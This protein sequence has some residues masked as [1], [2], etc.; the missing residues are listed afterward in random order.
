MRLQVSQYINII[1]S[2]LLYIPGPKLLATSSR[3]RILHVFDVEQ[4]YKLLQTLD[5]HSS[6]ITAVRFTQNDKQL[7]M[8][9]CGADK[10]LLFRNAQMVSLAVEQTNLFRK[11]QMVS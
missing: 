6:S 11:A 5:D 8:L 4:N 7:K 10:S 2:S 3:D 9:S 1:L